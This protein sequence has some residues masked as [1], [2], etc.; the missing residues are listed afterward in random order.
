[1]PVKKNKQV[2]AYI[3]K[4]TPSLQPVLEKIRAAVHKACPSCEEAMKWNVPWFVYKGPLLGMAAFTKH[5]S[6]GFWKGK[7]L[8]DPDGI[9]PGPRRA[10]MCTYKAET[11]K[12]LPSQAV[13]AKYIKAAMKLNDEGINVPKRTGSAAKSPTVPKE[14][15]AALKKNAKARKTFEAFPPSCQREYV[16]WITEA[17]REETRTKRLATTIEWLTEG[18]RRNWKYENC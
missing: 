7:L 12:D 3:A 8:P 1:M 6:F 16:D 4:Q 18:K 13:L 10:S 17:K 2:D 14:L 11:V 5:A 15:A 9:F